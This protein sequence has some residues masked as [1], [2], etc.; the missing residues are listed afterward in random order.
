MFIVNDLPEIRHG[1]I[2]RYAEEDAAV[3]LILAAVDFEWT[4]RRA[5][6]ALGKNPTKQIKIEVLAKSKN[7]GLDH[8]KKCWRTEV[9]PIYSIGLPDFIDGWQSLKNAFELRN[10]LV[11][12]RGVSGEAFTKARM[13]TC[14][15]ASEKLTKFAAEHCSPLYGQRIARIKPRE[16]C[17]HCVNLARSSK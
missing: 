3:G 7:S 2:R 11:H 9:F 12:G 17:T 5:I 8:Y 16:N 6:L 1:K 15:N 13:E 14:L 10:R 4:V